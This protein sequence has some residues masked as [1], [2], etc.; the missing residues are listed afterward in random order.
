MNATERR[1]GFAPKKLASSRRRVFTFRS[2]GSSLQNRRPRAFKGER[3]I[4]GNGRRTTLIKARQQMIVIM[5]SIRASGLKFLVGTDNAIQRKQKRIIARIIKNGINEI[6]QKLI[7]DGASGGCCTREI[8]NVLG[9]LLEKRISATRNRP[10]VDHKDGALARPGY[11]DR[12]HKKS[13]VRCALDLVTGV[14][15]VEFT[16]VKEN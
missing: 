5:P 14:S 16:A 13:G 15:V 6:K 8:Q 4:S 12:I 2:L 3:S 1:L 11:M 10:C 9:N 7:V